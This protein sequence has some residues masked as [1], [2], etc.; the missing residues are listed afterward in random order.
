MRNLRDIIL[1]V[2]ALPWCSGARKQTVQPIP[3]TR[4]PSDKPIW[5][6]VHPMENSA[7]TSDYKVP[8]EKKRNQVMCDV[9][10][11]MRWQEIYQVCRDDLISSL[12]VCVPMEKQHNQVT[13]DSRDT[14]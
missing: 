12:S 14:M 1:W 9:R 7:G 4:K 10:D 8:T 6:S 3:S 11:V 13:C 5:K 2:N